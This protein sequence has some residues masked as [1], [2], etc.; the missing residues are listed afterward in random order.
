[1]SEEKRV[2][3]ID[4]GTTYSVIAALDNTGKPEVFEFYSEGERVMPSAVYFQPEGVPVV[5]KE[6]KSMAETEPE[7]VVQWVKRQ[8]GKADVK[9]HFD[10]IE[11]GPIIISSLILKR[12]KED[13]EQQGK[14]VN[15]VVITCPAYFGNEEKMA[16]RQAGQ[17][18]GLNV[19]NIIHEP[20]AAAL[21]YC[22]RE[23]GEPRKIMVYDLG[24]GTF[25]VTLLNFSVDK[26]GKNAAIDIIDSKGD[27]K[28]GGIDWDS[29]L[30][31]HICKLYADS[32]NIEVS[33]IDDDIKAGIKIKVEDTKKA[34]SRMDVRSINAGDERIEVT[35]QDFE[36]VS[37]DL[38]D[39]TMNFV[40]QLLASNELTP[41]DVNTVLLVGGSSKMP[42][43][44]EAV[45]ALFPGKVRVEDPDFAVAK[46]AAIAAYMFITPL[47]VPVGPGGENDGGNSGDTSTGVGLIP[48]IKVNDKLSRSFGPAIWTRDSS[49]SEVF[50][51]N[52]IL[53]IGD[54]S[55]SEAE[56]VYGTMADNQEVVIIPV[57]ENVGK[58][59]EAHK[60]IVPSED[61]NGKLQA[62]DP[63][64]NVK[65]IGEVTL[66]LPAGTPAGSPIKVRFEC[67]TEGLTVYAENVNTGEKVK[68]TIQSK[69][70]KSEEE[71]LK[72]RQHLASFETKGT[73]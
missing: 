40:R 5:G 7:R 50:R 57:Y 14:E 34:L 29:R 26:D 15:D 58:D 41:D 30:F 47:P 64:L 65:K 12:I 39:R 67:S 42:M 66:N 38:V 10:G 37:K 59:R 36:Y 2:Y 44:Q 32:K 49:G 52:N 33:D 17:I 45:K 62:S 70:L 8:I 46:G 73:L 6:A 13:I 54:H 22:S 4:L 9:Y 60:F 61:E 31:D 11:Y 48:E 19:L 28:L 25:D 18:A 23:F 1:M 27:D 56:A 51:V 55:P 20:T 3:G 35:K 69:T 16:T 72:D 43:I 24:G 21:S 71:L 68:T 63:A 53:F